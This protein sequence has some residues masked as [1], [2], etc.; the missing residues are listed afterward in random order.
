[1]LLDLSRAI[2]REPDVGDARHYSRRV[3]WLAVIHPTLFLLSV[4][5]LAL[6]VARGRFFVTLSQRSNVETLTIA[7]LLLLFVY[8]SALT[9]RG[10]LGASRMAAFHLWARISRTPDA[11]EKRKWAALG[12]P[13]RGPAVALNKAIERA[14]SPG[15]PFEL[16][17]ADEI[18]SMGRLRVDGAT[19]EH[20]EALRGGS[21]S[22]LPYFARKLAEVTHQRPS[23]LE[24][25]HWRSTD[26]EALLQ[27]AATVEAMRALGR[28]V[29]APVWPTVTLSPSQCAALERHLSELCP[30]LRDEAFLPDWEFQGQH[31][32]PII[33]EPLGIVS[34]SRAERR[35]DPLSSMMALLVVVAGVV[36][37]IASFLW[38]APWVPGK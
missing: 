2:V 17:I 33:P 28:H 21:T 9:L 19:I 37:V 30:A 13:G 5:G 35:V 31:K 25:I 23:Q 1:M 14:G 32:L 22:L 11:V 20:V 10:A 36:A 7:F 12:R 24:V 8:L 34:L 38:R 27:Y 16:A 18:G 26:D 4:V 29:G 15:E 3:L 6:L